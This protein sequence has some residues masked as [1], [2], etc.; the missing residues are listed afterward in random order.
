MKINSEK[1]YWH[2]KRHSWQVPLLVA[3]LAT[4]FMIIATTTENSGLE[5]FAKLVWLFLLFV[6][7]GYN[8]MIRILRKRFEGQERP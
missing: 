5:I 2:I 7:L 6:L 3:L 4:P 1:F 8:T